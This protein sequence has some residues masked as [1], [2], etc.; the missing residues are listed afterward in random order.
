MPPTKAQATIL[1]A[2]AMG[3]ATS[4]ILSSNDYKVVFWDV[5]EKVVDNIN[6]LNKNPRSLPDVKLL[7]SVSAKND[8]IKSVADSDMVVFAVASPYVREVALRV[9]NAIARNAVIVITAKGLEASSLMTMEQVLKD[10]LG[11]DFHNRIVVLSGPTLALEVATKKSTAA[12]LASEKDNPYYQRSFEAF[13]ADWF[14]V[15]PTRDVIGVELSGVAK[16]VM[17]IASGIIDGIDLGNNA[18]SWVLTEGFRDMSRLIWKLGG[19]ETTVYGLAGFGDIIVSGL[20][21]QGRNRAFGE[22]LGKGNTVVKAQSIIKETVEGIEAVESLHKLALRE[23]L[24]L[25]VLQAVFDIV[26]D[27]QKAKKVFEELLKNL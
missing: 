9:K 5:E 1:G 12:I 10:A 22:L 25:P 21:G 17:S 8:L 23:K 18:K 27:K 6:N 2:G 11:G 20:C 7:K 26:A 15:Y 4:V 13:S 3:M 14:K 19:Q 16:H 24:R